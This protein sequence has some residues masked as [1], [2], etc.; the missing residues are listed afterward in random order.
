[1]QRREF[2][3]SALA[4]GAAAGTA[5][6]PLEAADEKPRFYELISYHLRIGD[7]SRRMDGWAQ[8]T[9]IPVAK[10]HGVSSLGCFGLEL[11]VDSPQLL[12]LAEHSSLA[13][14]ESRWNAI[15]NDPAWK[16]GL[17]ARETGPGP[18]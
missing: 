17:S 14:M 7:Q 13:E 8:K 1:M 15:S 12:V 18:P 16:E 9:L 4:A 6:V 11:G 5:S 3:R 10:K 2:I